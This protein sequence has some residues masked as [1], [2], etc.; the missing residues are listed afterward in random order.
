[1]KKIKLTLLL[2]LTSACIHAQT[3]GSGKLIERS[4][5]YKGFDK[6]AIEDLDGRVEIEIGKVWSIS[7]VI[8]DNLFP[9]LAFEENPTEYQLKIAFRGNRDNKMYIEDTNVLIK[10]TMP[11]ASVIKNNSNAVIV[12]NNAIGGYLR[13]E[14]LDNGA[15]KASGKVDL[16]DVSCSGNGTIS[17]GELM[18]KTAEIKGSGNGNILVNVDQKIIAKISGNGSVKNIGKAKYAA[19]S[20]RTGNGNLL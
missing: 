17:A 19:N 3:R 8:D 12:V 10:I 2:L 16:L 13:L 9:L 18:V 7:V 14:N 4:Y 15:I 20:K 11:E 6:I 1:M 5:P